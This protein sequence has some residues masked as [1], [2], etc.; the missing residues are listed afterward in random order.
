M[1]RG[2]SDSKFSEAAHQDHR[3]RQ[4]RKMTRGDV[5][6]PTR[7]WESLRPSIVRTRPWLDAIADAVSLA[8]VTPA[9]VPQS[10]GSPAK[11]SIEEATT[12]STDKVCVVNGVGATA[13]ATVT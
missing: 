6:I 7:R 3:S 11:P 1:A 2:A 8:A 5:R 12:R 10:C 13:E 4:L 9:L